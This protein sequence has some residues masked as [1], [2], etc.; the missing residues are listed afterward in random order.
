MSKRLFNREP[1]KIKM[2]SIHN[3]SNL[4]NKSQAPLIINKLRENS[5]KMLLKPQT[6]STALDYLQRSLKIRGNSFEK[7]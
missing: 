7:L 3:S 4:H 6:E 1:C 5:L 2:K